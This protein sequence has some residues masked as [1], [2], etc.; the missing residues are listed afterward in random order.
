MSTNQKNKL[1]GLSLFV[2]LVVI[3]WL[4]V[5]F[6]VFV[7]A[8]PRFTS[9][10]DVV[11][12]QISDTEVNT[13]T[14]ISALLGINDTSVEDANYLTEYILSND[15]VKNLDT[16]F[17]F[18]E[19]YYVDGSDPIYEIDPDASQEDLLEYFKKSTHRLE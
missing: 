16:T 14:G 18:R 1:I 10:S 13:G 15:M 8:H 5:V 6:Y 19:A 11:V 7:L 3:P 12:K 17:N 9:T 4:L 2:G